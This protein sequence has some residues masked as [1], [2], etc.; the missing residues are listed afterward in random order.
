MH[1]LPRRGRS[2]IC[3]R[4][5]FRL[6]PLDKDADRLIRD[7]RAPAE[8]QPLNGVRAKQRLH[9]WRL[10]EALHLACTELAELPAGV[11]NLFDAAGV[12]VA[13]PA[14]VEALQVEA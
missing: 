7:A 2:P 12:H 11:D 10:V 14:D 9:D 6:C 1:Q 5:H 13:A 4:V 3:K 8:M